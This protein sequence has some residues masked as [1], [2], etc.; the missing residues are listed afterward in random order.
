MS[1]ILLGV[2][3]LMG[4]ASAENRRSLIFLWENG[5]V[6]LMGYHRP[7]SRLVFEENSKKIG[8]VTA[9][10][11]GSF[12]ISIALDANQFHDIVARAF[13]HFGQEIK[14]E[15][16]EP[17]LLQTRVLPGISKTGKILADDGTPIAGARVDLVDAEGKLLNRFFTDENGNYAIT[18]IPQNAKVMIS[19]D[20]FSE[21]TFPAETLETEISLGFLEGK[22]PEKIT[23]DSNPKTSEIVNKSPSEKASIFLWSFW[24]ILLAIGTG[25][26]FL[27]WKKRKT[28]EA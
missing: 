2:F 14:T 28:N 21:E 25:I 13:D 27:I 12:E 18:G 8:E 10:A 4:N 7:Y 24:G 5:N 3:L 19:G 17:D 16:G 9:D 26:G 22:T 11:R 1:G 15:N 20:D 6:K 23:L